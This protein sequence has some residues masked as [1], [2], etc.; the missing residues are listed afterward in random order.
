[1]ATERLYYTDPYLAEFE[2]QTVEVS[3][4]GRRVYLDRTAFYP[5]SGGQPHDLGWLGGR[6]VV[7]VI[8][9]DDR[10][11]HLT[12]DP[13]EAG[14]IT[15]KIHWPRRYDHMQQ[16]TGQHLLSAVFSN[17]FGFPTLSFHMGDEVSTIELGTKELTDRQID[18]AELS[19]NDEARLARRVHIG[20]EEAERAEGLRK[21]SQRS[22]TLRI[23]E[24]EGI[25]KSACGGTH[26]HSLAETLPLQ[27]RRLEKVRG[28]VRVEFVCGRRATQRAKQDYRIAQEL[29]KL[30]AAPI[31]K[32]P[33]VFAALKQRFA[34]AEKERQSLAES[35]ARREGAELYQATAPTADGLRRA[36][37][38]VEG[39][40]ET[41]RSKALAYAAGA[42]SL[43]LVLSAKD[44]LIACSSDAGID[45]GAVLKQT[46]AEFGG[47][48]GGSA[49]LAQGRVADT[50]CALA[51]A[52][53]LGV[54]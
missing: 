51:L 45:A 44:A 21:Q 36:F 4:D 6:P 32:L 16:H 14:P 53:E 48:G 37:W 12:A 9:E 11:A 43:V 30:S 33:E 54:R 20:F 7:D 34:V 38:K 40:D 27:I 22:G 28:H 24:I 13:V 47:K 49:T 2:A 19:A 23:I 18:E 10:I 31:A 46:L 35:L 5:A 15:G 1:M 41:V 17:L 29:A 3:S 50:E 25:D 52:R 8:D 39:I 42:R 26:V